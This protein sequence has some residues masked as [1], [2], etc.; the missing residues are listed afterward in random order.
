[1][2]RRL[3]FA[4]LLLLGLGAAPGQA[5]AGS[6]PDLNAAVE[7]GSAITYAKLVAS[8]FKGAR[9]DSLT[10]EMVTASDKVLRRPGS[11][12]RTTVPAESGLESFEA[13]WV[14]GDGRRY[15]VMFWTAKTE[16]TEVPGHDACI[17]AVFP[18][19]S[20]EPQDVA[21]VKTDMFCTLGQDPLPSLGPDD[22]FSVLN[23]HSNSNQSY[24]DTTLFHIHQGRLRVAAS[25]FTLSVRGLCQD[26][27]QEALTWRGEP[28]DGSP[29]PR[30]LATVTLTSGP[31]GDERS[32]CPQGQRANRQKVFTGV[33]AWDKAKERYLAQG[34]GLEALD[35][36][37]QDRF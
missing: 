6:I 17:L 2:K 23:H 32:G 21:E 9:P 36:F 1:M 5:W 8:V 27:F 10:G 11:K 35:R 30:L 37:N 22:A 28:R 29:Y 18:Q 19:G 20:A 31:Q 26:S 12:E 34:K 7:P 15:L 13:I 3:F 14:R 33:F 24:L 16:A 25:V 4:W